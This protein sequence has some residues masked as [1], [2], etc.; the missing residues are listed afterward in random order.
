MN[1]LIKKHKEASASYFSSFGF[2]SRG[3]TLIKVVNDVMQFV[4]FEILGNSWRREIRIL[5]AV[6]PLSMVISE[7]T[8]K[9][10][11][12]VYHLRQF[13]VPTNQELDSWIYEP[14]SKENMNDVID[15]ILRYHA[16]YLMPLFI[17][18][19]S[20]QEALPELIKLEKHQ[21]D[22]R[23]EGLRKSGIADKARA[24]AYKNS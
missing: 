11:L 2:I 8:T 24:H 6:R 12:G 4:D 14:S 9:G 20:C 1:Y 10:Q 18:A 19:E 21:N 17:A 3:R 5:F 7:E 16:E 15:E 22:V 13:E 23:K